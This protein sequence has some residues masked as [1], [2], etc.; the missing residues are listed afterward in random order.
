MKRHVLSSVVLI[1][2]V[3][4]GPL[5]GAE[6]AQPIPPR[7][8]TFQQDD[9]KGRLAVHVDGKEAIVYQHAPTEDLCHFWPV[10]SPSGKS[11]TV[12]HPK[13][14]EKYPHHR[15]FWF[16][17]TVKLAGQKRRVSFYNA[18]YSKRGKKPVPKEFPDRVRH[19]K[20]SPAPNA[21]G[22]Y[23]GGQAVF[24]IHLVWE[25][26]FK[27]PVLDEVRHMR[28]V[29]LES[30]EYFLDITFT[31]TA[32]YG[33]VEVVSDAT[34]YAWP[35]IR[36]NTTFNVANGGGTL[37]NSEGKVNR[38]ATN[39]QPAKWVDYSATVEGK[40]EGLAV[41]SHPDNPQPHKWLTRD[42]GC[43]GPRRED[44]RSGRKFTLKKSESLQRR[45]G[46]L[47]HSGD[48]KTGKVAK[49]FE[50]YVKGTL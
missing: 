31:M 41:F 19:V 13:P 1:V 35:Y 23:R 32:A 4:S 12:Q 24:D 6:K 44:A 15:S 36:M 33:D 25:M 20:F 3:V 17:D 29:P 47:V 10:R 27:T 30:G 7:R 8:I 48:V 45:V 46:I 37:T 50:Q 14:P 26:D 18:W 5:W 38:K 21:P 11:M 49:R 39:M 16:G 9:A 42:Y 40:T 34:H 28:I 22:V 2:S 43:F